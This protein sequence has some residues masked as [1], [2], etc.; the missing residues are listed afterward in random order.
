M[1]ERV[2]DH[3]KDHVPR[4]RRAETLQ[5]D[6]HCG[7]DHVVVEN[8]REHPAHDADDH[9]DDRDKAFAKLIAKR[10]DE[11]DGDRHG[12]RAHDT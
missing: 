10:R 5:G 9:T 12:H 4:R 1:I 3:R 11:D 6:A 7:D 8:T 2:G